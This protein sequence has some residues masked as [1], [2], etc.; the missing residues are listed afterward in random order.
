[1]PY[2]SAKRPS[3]EPITPGCKKAMYHSREEAEDMIRHI[4]E[5]RVVMNLRAY[6][7][8]VCGQWH[9]TSKDGD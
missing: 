7:C 8:P 5:D 2:K 1:M 3:V 9:L 6:L 4:L